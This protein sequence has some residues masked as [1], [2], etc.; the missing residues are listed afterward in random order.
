L[1]ISFKF[2]TRFAAKGRESALWRAE[3]GRVATGL[4]LGG[5]FSPAAFHPGVQK[6]KLRPA[7]YKRAGRLAT[8]RLPV[9]T[10]IGA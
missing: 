3:I 7:S 1:L 8:S 4:L 2:A 9:K 5:F 10:E 6:A